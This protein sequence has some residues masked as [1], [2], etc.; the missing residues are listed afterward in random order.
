MK[1]VHLIGNAHLD[2]VWLWRWQEGFAEIKATFKSALDRMREFEDF[3]FTSACGAYYMW[4]EK[5]DPAMFEEIRQRVKEGRWEL[6]GGWMIQPDCNIPC[7]E[8]FA[9]HA[10]I[11]Q[12]YFAEKFGK[13]AE[14]GY[15]VDSFGHNGSL[16]MIL[17]HSR[18]KHYVFMRPMA[19][20]KD[21]PAHLFSWESADGSRVD[22]YR[23]PFYYNIDGNHRKFEKLGQIAEIDEDSDQMAFYGVGNHGGGPTVELLKRMH[24]ELDGRFV[25]STTGAYFAAQDTSALPAVRDDLQYHAKGCYSAFSEIKKNNRTAENKLL[26]A[27]RLSVLSAHLMDT[28]YPAEAYGRAWYNV[29]FNQFHDILGGCSIRGAYE[30]ARFSHGESMAIA[31][32]EQNFAIQQ[33]G[34]NIHTVMGDIGD[35]VTAEEAERIGLPIVVFNPHAYP[36]TSVVRVSSQNFGKANFTY[37]T[38]VSGNAHPVQRVRA[39]RTNGGSDHYDNLFLATVPALGYTVYRGHTAPFEGELLQNPFTVGE[40]FVSN[41]Y[42]R[43][44]FD[45]DGELC[46][47]VDEESGKE[48]LSAPARLRLC[49]DE[50]H[51]TWAHG[52]EAFDEELP[53]NVTGSFRIAEA[54]PVRA[55]V[56]TEQEFGGSRMV[57]EY[58]LTAE[59]NAVE[60]R[61][62]VDYHERFGI[63]K[64]VWPTA[65]EEKCYAKI[66]F[67]HIE[68]PTDGT[69]QVC[70]DWIALGELAVANDCKYSFDAKDNELSLTVLRSALF[71][72]HYGKRDEYCEHMEQGEHRFAYSL[73]PF[74][75]FS[76]VQRQADILQ[77]P[78]A[79]YAETFHRGSLP[80][81]FK[82]VAISAENVTVTAVKA[83]VSGRGTVIRFLETAGQDTTVRA[84]LLGTGFEFSIGHNAV[85]TLWLCDGAVTETDFVE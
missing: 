73:A 26:C 39:P 45:A 44:T 11:T 57:R 9:R 36:V 21:L 6:T 46:S 65:G 13:M 50:K 15:N 68:R 60:V 28:P 24:A 40:N 81:T 67:G 80:A 34:W 62:M 56:R 37:V 79:A 25:Y 18:M 30:D 4:I 49:N 82:G 42:I 75:G 43:M 35:H 63:L 29:L 66:P 19:H 52:I 2:P 70:G 84:E 77:M 16:P 10:L 33:I 64:L 38:D 12:R 51:D 5:S 31:D 41:G 83:H 7:G 27:E 3:K 69:E 54:G 74:S 85:K 17:N 59:A 71:A 72:D 14:T 78:L 22:T 32:R 47:L 8:S 58:I 61:A 55:V 20:E 1:T 23:I 76:A 53:L 48:L